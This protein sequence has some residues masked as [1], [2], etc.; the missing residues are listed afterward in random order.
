ML[1]RVFPWGMHL[2][3]V[4]R[5]CAILLVT[6]SSTLRA[7]PDDPA[8]LQ[9]RIVEGEGD[10]FTPGS[11]ATRG[12]TVQ[13]SDETGKPVDEATISFRL[14][15]EGPGGVFANGSRLEVATTR[16]DGRAAVWGMLWN[17]TPGPF[18]I[19]ITAAKGSAR[20]GAICPLY[21]TE[22]ASE[23]PP[24][25]RRIGRGVP[26]WLWVT[27]AVGAGAA[28]LGAAA[29]ARGSNTATAPATAISAPR[30]GTPTISI[31]RP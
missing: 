31:G 4:F 25:P 2:I 3:H 29:I 21:L 23:T 13:V 20:A 7:A 22:G 17:H 14:P 12:I 28:G 15:E 18:E 26:K 11:R 10:G 30:L 9:I 5:R 1:L 8:I 6:L 16:A 27:V 19:R 24:G